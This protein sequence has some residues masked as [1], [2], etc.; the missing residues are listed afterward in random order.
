MEYFALCAK[1]N[2]TNTSGQP[3]V[4]AAYVNTSGVNRSI[5]GATACSSRVTMLPRPEEAIAT[6]MCVW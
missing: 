4:C 1:L 2:G 3:R 5:I 6:R